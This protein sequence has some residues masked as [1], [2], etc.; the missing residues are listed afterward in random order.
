MEP[1]RG[2]FPLGV[3]YPMNAAQDAAYH[4][5]NNGRVLFEDLRG[6]ALG[7]EE[8]GVNSEGEKQMDIRSEGTKKITLFQYR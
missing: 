6:R 4:G 1:L 2:S 8:W 3:S 7:N 5:V